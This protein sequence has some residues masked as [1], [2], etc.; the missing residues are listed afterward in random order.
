M[1]G[2]QKAGLI[3]VGMVLLAALVFWFIS[4]NHIPDDDC[5]S[6]IA[7]TNRD[8]SIDV[9]AKSIKIGANSSA[10]QL[11]KLT[12][13]SQLVIDRAIRLCRMHKSGQISDDTFEKMFV[14]LATSLKA[15]NLTSSDDGA[16]QDDTIKNVLETPQLNITAHIQSAGDLPGRE[17]TWVGTKGAGKRLEGFSATIEAQKQILEIE[18]MCH[19]QGFGDTTWLQSEQF[20]G[21]RN[22]GRRIE[23]LAFRLKGSMASK[24]DVQYQCHLQGIGDT[25]TKSNGDFCG[26]A[27]EQRRLEAFKVSVIPK[28]IE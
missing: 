13:Q 15:E 12:N 4:N 18:Y 20:C 5:R 24:F 14:G 6:D 1:S 27:G 21:T 16:Q 23:G 8:F 11:E 25:E 9:E 22:E 26:T 2:S 7:S 19:I 17:G 28:S 10:V 3:L